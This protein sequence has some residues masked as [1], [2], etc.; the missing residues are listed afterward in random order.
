MV[1]AKA[2]LRSGVSSFHLGRYREAK[3]CFSEG[4]KLGEE[5]H[6]SGQ[7]FSQ[8]WSIFIS[9][10]TIQGGKELFLRGAKIGRRAPWFWPKLFSEVE[11]LHFTWDDTGRQRTVSQRGKNW[12]KSS[13]VLAKAFLRSGVSSFHLG[14]YREAK[15]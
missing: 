14:R 12:E 1:L 13:M 10:G 6:G 11:Y 9:P 3:N 2:F 5:L 8:K 7:S 4:Q 15:N